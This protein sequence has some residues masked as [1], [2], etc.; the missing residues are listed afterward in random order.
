[1]PRTHKN[2]KLLTQEEQVL[3]NPDM[4][5]G[6]TDSAKWIFLRHGKNCE[7][8]VVPACWKLFDELI[9]NVQDVYEKNRANP[10]E[11]NVSNVWITVDWEKG[12]VTV[13]NDGTGVPI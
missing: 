2:Y 3:Q 4:F 13:K 9:V 12:I 6:K 5:V 7:K 11:Q 10:Q 8:N 1:M